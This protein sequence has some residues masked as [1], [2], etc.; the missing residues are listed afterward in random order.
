MVA[1][2]LIAF[3]WLSMVPLLRSMCIAKGLDVK[4]RISFRLS[5]R[6]ASKLDRLGAEV[7]C[8]LCKARLG[9]KR[10]RS[11]MQAKLKARPWF[12]SQVRSR[13]DSRWMA[14]D[15]APAAILVHSNGALC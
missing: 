7:S 3:R 5:L 4:A 15:S 10:G 2:G 14:F 12:P 13:P 6:P 9:S 1:A 11:A 8:L